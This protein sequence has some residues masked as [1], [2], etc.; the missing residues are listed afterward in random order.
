MF[1]KEFIILLKINGMTPGMWNK[2]CKLFRKSNLEGSERKL[3]ENCLN[4][5]SNIR[6]K[7]NLKGIQIKEIE[8]LFDGVRNI[9]LK[10]QIPREI[11]EKKEV[12]S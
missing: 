6:T 1:R 2:F 4:I 7:Y 3:Y 10:E 5:V 9:E 12:V 11:Y 8:D